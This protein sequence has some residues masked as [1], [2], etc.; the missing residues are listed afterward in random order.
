VSPVLPTDLAGSYPGQRLIEVTV[1]DPEL[2]GGKL[3]NKVALLVHAEIGGRS[4]GRTPFGSKF[5]GPDSVMVGYP[6]KLLEK[7]T[8]LKVVTLETLKVI[9]T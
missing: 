8:A 6:P 7:R 1:K 2:G 4:R 9:Y 5:P 3:I